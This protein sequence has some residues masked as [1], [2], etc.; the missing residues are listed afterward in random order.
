MR[1]VLSDSFNTSGGSI[2][3]E[4]DISTGDLPGPGNPLGNTTPVTVLE[5]FR[6]EPMRDAPL[7][8]VHDIAPK[9]KLV[10]ATA[11]DGEVEFANNIKRLKDEFNADVIVDDVFYFDEPYFQDG[12]IAQAVDY[13]AAKGVA[14]F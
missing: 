1:F 10:F 6:A 5:D 8:I 9:A 11:D 13:V 3:A 14:Y 4:T 12:I 7:Q 2:T